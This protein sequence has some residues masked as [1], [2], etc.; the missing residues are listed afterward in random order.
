MRNKKRR[1]TSF[2]QA[3]QDVVNFG[4]SL[5]R[6]EIGL[7]KKVNLWILKNPVVVGKLLKVVVC[8]SCWLQLVG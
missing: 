4:C 6:P 3:W 5:S 2:L 1:A 8:R 7:H